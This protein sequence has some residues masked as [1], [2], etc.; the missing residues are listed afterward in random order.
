MCA[1]SNIIVFECAKT[2]RVAR[3]LL[4]VLVQSLV[5]LHLYVTPR[6]SA[7]THTHT[8]KRKVISHSGVCVC[9]C[10]FRIVLENSKYNAHIKKQTTSPPA[11]NAVV[12]PEPVCRARFLI[13][14]RVSAFPPP[15]SVTRLSGSVGRR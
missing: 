4:Q 10:T 13:C 15:P 14:V 1:H 3:T 5:S 2:D 9:V 7:H 11:I 12:K 6:R 8:L